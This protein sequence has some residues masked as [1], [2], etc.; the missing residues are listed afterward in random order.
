MQ[1]MKCTL[2]DMCC[3]LQTQLKVLAYTD[4]QRSR[5]QEVKSFQEYDVVLASYNTVLWESPLKHDKALFRSGLLTW[6]WQSNF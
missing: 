1:Q 6:P 4:S 2:Q 3:L 5:H